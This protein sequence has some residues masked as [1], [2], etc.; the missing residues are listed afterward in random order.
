VL[1]SVTVLQ[2]GLASPNPLGEQGILKGGKLFGKRLT[3]GIAARADGI[4][5][6]E[7]L[8]HSLSLKS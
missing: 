3:L 2:S 8:G 6:R 7:Q 4:S 5:S 1:P